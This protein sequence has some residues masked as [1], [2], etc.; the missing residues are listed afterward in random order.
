MTKQ[1][2]R[3]V[4][5]GQ[6][7]YYIT[8]AEWEAI[9]SGSSFSGF[10]DANDVVTL[11]TGRQFSIGT[12]TDPTVLGGGSVMWIEN[13]GSATRANQL[14]VYATDAGRTNNNSSSIHVVNSAQYD[15]TAGD[16][17]AVGIRIIHDPLKSAGSNLLNNVGLMI[18]TNQGDTNQAI[19]VTHGTCK[20]DEDV[21]TGPFTA[22]GNFIMS[23]GSCSITGTA[24]SSLTFSGAGGNIQTASGAI[25]AG[26]DITSTGGNLKM[27]G[28]TLW[29]TDSSDSD[30]Y[31]YADSAGTSGNQNIN[32]MAGGT[33][34][35]RIN[36]NTAGTTHTG[37]GGFEVWAG[38]NSTTKL[39]D[40]NGGASPTIGVFGAAAVT[41]RTVTGSRGSNAAL[42]SLL[43]AFAEYGWITDSSS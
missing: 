7:D 15:T 32:I 5:T 41:K 18:D 23:G 12:D 33:G 29:F 40:I 31:I 8:A 30:L 11:A 34:V 37:T 2:R 43:T 10:V 19:W 16:I 39:L 9:A 3:S 17:Q 6:A 4:P 38:D 36:S 42:A 13:F 21:L 22:E 25:V 27:A 20:F 35:V 28:N 14:Y 26:G 1:D 24:N